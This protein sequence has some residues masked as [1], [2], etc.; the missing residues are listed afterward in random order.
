M[1]YYDLLGVPP[2]AS[3]AD[4]KAA[5]RSK[6]MNL[7]PDRNINRDT[8]SEFQALQ[9]AYAVL[10]DERSRQQ[11]DADTAISDKVS[12]EDDG[13]YKPFEPIYCSKCN[14][15]SAQPRYKVFYSVFG[16]LVGA[17]KKSHQGIFCSNCEIKEGLKASAITL[18]AG[19]W[20]IAGFLWSIQ[21]LLQNLIG[22]RFNEQNARLQAYQAM[23]FA[24]IGKIEIARAI[25]VEALNLAK[26]S[27]LET[28]SILAF[29]KSLGYQTTE[30]LQ[31][32][33]DS[34]TSFINSLPSSIKIVEL[35]HSDVVFN[36]RFFAQIILLAFFSGTIYTAWYQ[37]DLKKRELE[38][39]RLEQEGLERA[40]SAAIAAAELET[41][42]KAE[43]PLPLSGVY[44][45]MI[46]WQHNTSNL[47]PFKIVNAPDSNALVKLIRTTDGIE[48]MSIFVRAGETIEVGVPVGS[49]R[50]K[51]ASGQ[52]WYGDAI[53]FGPKTN[54]AVLD[55]PLNFSIEG[56]HLQGHAVTLTQVRNGNLRQIQINAKDF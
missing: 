44:R 8:T 40:R 12:A 35:K 39:V 22:G 28:D 54:Y 18:I 47:P 6:A 29:R 4:I 37:Q 53:R 25:A 20:S 23:Y 42:R 10:S 1:N 31:E 19:W 13:S 45:A 46:E 52:T 17:Y 34:L 49:Y 24:Q 7:H 30:P 16:Y 50:A 27:S 14:A 5:Y 33:Q 51:I 56:I 38:R 48:V 15:V 21:T 26:K 2:D 3:Q 43:R 55:S 11:Y 36:K 41:L 32:L 9:A